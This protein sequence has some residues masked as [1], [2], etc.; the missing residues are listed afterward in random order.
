M[1]SWNLP[2][3]CK[4]SDH[5]RPSDVATEKRQNYEN[6]DKQKQLRYKK[7]TLSCPVDCP[8]RFL[9]TFTSIFARTTV[10]SPVI[11]HTLARPEQHKHNVQLLS[12]DLSQKQTLLH[13]NSRDFSRL[14]RVTSQLHALQVHSVPIRFFDCKRAGQIKLQCVIRT[15]LCV[16][17]CECV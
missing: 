17:A 9:G 5:G 2:I 13:D 15:H 11:K 1:A 12:S 7:L 6:S 16:C 4:G 14:S 8:V 3:A 10:I